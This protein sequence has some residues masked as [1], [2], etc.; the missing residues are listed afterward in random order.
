MDD[1]SQKTLA[2]VQD[3]LG[4][5]LSGK[6]CGVI[7]E[8][9]TS[10]PELQTLVTDMNQLIQNL[11]EINHLAIDLSRGKLDTPIPSRHNYMAGP[12]KRLHSQ[13]SSLSWCLRQLGT[14]AVVSKFE[15]TGELFDACNELI[16]QVA[17]FSTQEADSA[18][19]IMPISFNSWRY[20]QILH[21]LDL[22]HVSV[23]EVD[24]NGHVVYANLSAKE[25]F[26]DIEYI[27]G[28]TESNVLKLIAANI[29]INKEDNT[30]PVHREIYEESSS[31]WYRITSDRFLLPNG[32]AVFFN[33]IDDISEW[34]INEYHLK[35]SAAMDEM[36]GTY[37]RKSGL[38]ELENIVAQSISSKTHCI[39][40]VDIDS[41]KPINDNYGHREGDYAIKSIANVLLS[42]VRDSDMVCRYGGDEFMI[43]FK[44]CEEDTAEKIIARMYDKLEEL[45]NKSP[46]P[47]PLSF[48]YGIISFSNCSNSAFN[49]A[50]LLKQADQRMYQCKAQKRRYREELRNND[51]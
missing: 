34:K 6:Q 15:N 13:L 25:I 1:M 40:F 38:E 2:A 48:S 41:L 16:D 33:T 3:A 24:S 26:G 22:L 12:L 37:N 18:A 7:E 17:V 36:T 32:Q 45:E 46:K 5:L 20:H 28:Q 39:A 51:R 44:N 8:V 14:G 30:F 10:I 42:S 29:A 35:M 11:N 43:I 50:D 9:H 19:P 31:T 21:T 4:K 23:L 27:S 49:A 47:Y